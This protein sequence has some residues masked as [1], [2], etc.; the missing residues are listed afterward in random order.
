ML[1]RRHKTR[2]MLNLIVFFAVGAQTAVAC[3]NIFSIPAR[4]AH[5][6]PW[7][8]HMRPIQRSGQHIQRSWKLMAIAYLSFTYCCCCAQTLQGAACR[9]PVQQT[10]DKTVEGGQAP[11]WAYE[12]RISC[13]MLCKVC[14]SAPIHMDNDAG[15]DLS[16]VRAGHP[17]YNGYTAWDQRL[18]QRGCFSRRA[19]S[20]QWQHL[21]PTYAHEQAT[22]R[23]AAQ[24]PMLA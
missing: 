24:S 19:A 12:C 14:F 8:T 2:V 7:P 9:R 5:G 16:A 3:S 10:M 18:R 23:V 1:L 13:N 21:T 6:K 15:A 11:S 20:I 22:A 17:T 4:A